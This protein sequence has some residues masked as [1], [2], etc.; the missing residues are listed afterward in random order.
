MTILHWVS[1]DGNTITRPSDI[2]A[3]IETLGPIFAG[4]EVQFRSGLVK[5]VFKIITRRIFK[6]IKFH[7]NIFA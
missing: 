6:T 2:P 3:D 1:F 7:T 4:V 5:G